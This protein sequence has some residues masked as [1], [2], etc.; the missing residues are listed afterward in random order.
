MCGPIPV[1]DPLARAFEPGDRVLH[2]FEPGRVGKVKIAKPSSELVYVDWPAHA[3]RSGHT[4]VHAKANLRHA[5]A[6]EL[7]PIGTKVRV[8]GDTE[9]TAHGKRPGALGEVVPKEGRHQYAI[10]P[11]KRLVATNPNRREWGPSAGGDARYVDVADLELVEAPAP[12]DP[13][14]AAL[15]HIPPRPVKRATEEVR[16]RRPYDL[17]PGDVVVSA[18]NP[19]TV[20]P[21]RQAVVVRREVKPDPEPAQFGTADVEGYGRLR[22]F[23]TGG[24]PGM[25]RVF[26]APTPEGG[27]VYASGEAFSGFEL[28]AS[29]ALPTREALVEAIRGNNYSTGGI[30][31]GRAADRV[32]NLLK[33]TADA[34]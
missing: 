1:T 33:E 14:P 27:Y 7:F 8:T 5:P 4:S 23:L 2:T 20:S 11:S 29:P 15:S 19:G 28:D 12:P 31:P 34:R 6:E 17:F 30:T 21:H 25:D 9:R 24:T 16:V 22:G 26:S 18:P 3:G 10:N 13:A 32:L